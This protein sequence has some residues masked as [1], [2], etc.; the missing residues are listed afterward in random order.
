MRGGESWKRERDEC[1]AGG[2]GVVVV[3]KDP[4]CWADVCSVDDLLMMCAK[5]S[6]PTTLSTQTAAVLSISFSVIP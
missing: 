5:I 1:G 3:V 2:L 6:Q 4:A